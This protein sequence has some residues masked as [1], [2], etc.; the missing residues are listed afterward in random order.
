MEIKQ[1]KPGDTYRKAV[2]TTPPINYALLETRRHFSSLKRM[3]GFQLAQFSP[4]TT[5]DLLS[6]EEK[7]KLATHMTHKLHIRAREDGNTDTLEGTVNIMQGLK[8]PI[9]MYGVTGHEGD[10]A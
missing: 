6:P 1:E 4:V 2:E 3:V 8:A 5:E 10:A 7:W 9:P